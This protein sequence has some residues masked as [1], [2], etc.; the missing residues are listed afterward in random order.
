MAKVFTTVLL[1]KVLKLF[2]TLAIL[3]FTLNQASFSIYASDNDQLTSLRNEAKIL[4]NEK[5]ELERQIDSIQ[6]T[7]FQYIE[8]KKLTEQKLNVLILE[9][10]NIQNQINQYDILIEQKQSELLLLEQQ[11]KAQY[12]LF[13]KRVRFLEERGEISYWAVLFNSKSFSE[14][15]DNYITVEELMEYDNSVAEKLAFLQSQVSEA[16][17]E[18]T[19]QKTI[20]LQLKCQQEEAITELHEQ[21]QQITTLIENIENQ[22]SIL[23]KE[24]SKLDKEADNLDKE[25]SLLESQLSNQISQIIDE[26]KYLWPLDLQYNILSSLY[27]SRIHPITHKAGQHTGIDIP[28]PANQEI[29]AIKSGIVIKSTYNNSY[30]NYVVISHSDGSSSLYAHMNRR[31][32][33]KGDKV[34]QGDVIGFVGT[35]GSS[36]GNHLHLELRKNGIRQDPINAYPNLKLNVSYNNEIAP[37]N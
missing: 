16:K 30:G 3:I 34:T 11:K 13:C 37:L 17:D 25:I 9:I 32:V 2:F 5:L 35:T 27:G 19:T 22:E 6:D 10:E 31:N 21:E 33:N 7:K 15:L 8:Q 18:L 29:Y 24:K 14:F 12:D 36:T 23:E 28:A 20:Q 4:E 1:Q 26:S